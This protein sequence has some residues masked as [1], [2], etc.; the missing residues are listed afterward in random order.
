[1][2]RGESRIML[3][4]SVWVDAL[5]GKTRRITELTR[6]LLKED[7]ALTCAP[8]IFEL[9][10]GLRPLER[11]RILPLIDAIPRLPVGD[12]IW[13]AAGD[14]AGSLRKKGVTLPP[15]DL[16]IAQVCIHQHVPLLTLD[17]HFRSIPGLDLVERPV[18]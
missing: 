15:M 9:R 2:N 1:M 12:D 7:R 5:R 14:L 3:D 16:L 4:T 10:R 17:R 8:V 13:D 18:T 11:E 6:V